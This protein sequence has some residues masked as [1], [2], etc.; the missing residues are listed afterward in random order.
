MEGFSLEQREPLE[1][2]VHQ[3][4]P[5]E[6]FPW[7]QPCGHMEDTTAVKKS[8][9]AFYFELAADL[10]YCPHATSFLGIEHA[11]VTGNVSL[12]VG[13]RAQSLQATLVDLK[14]H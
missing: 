14:M 11:I 7:G 8:G 9:A 4:L 13:S 12:G 2:V 6:M 5:K 3:E 1:Y 10:W